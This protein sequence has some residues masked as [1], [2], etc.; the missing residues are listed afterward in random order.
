MKRYPPRNQRVFIVAM[1]VKNRRRATECSL[2]KKQPQ[3][4]EGLGPN[5]SVTGCLQ[6]RGGDGIKFHANS[7]LEVTESGVDHGKDRRTIRSGA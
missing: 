1:F 6:L 2:Q 3:T 4:R 7:R 5:R